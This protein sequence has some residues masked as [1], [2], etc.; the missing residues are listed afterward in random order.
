MM[1]GSDEEV[2]LG[3]DM[4]SRRE[5]S[6]QVAAE[7]D[8]EVQRIVDSAYDVAVDLLNQ[9]IEKLHEVAKALLEYETIS[10]DEFVLIMD[11]SYEALISKRG[12]SDKK[13][14]Q[15]KELLS[16]ESE[17]KMPESKLESAENESKPSENESKSTE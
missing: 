17:T 16:N 7:I 3:R 11:K 10:G 8:R 2:F 5:F 4:T 14:L 15:D 6:E 13:E 9:N 1:Y 12:A